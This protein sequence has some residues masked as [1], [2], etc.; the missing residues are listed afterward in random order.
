M[1]NQKGALPFIIIIAG[2]IIVLAFLVTIFK[3]KLFG[4]SKP[5]PTPSSNQVSLTPNP[6]SLAH[7]ASP[8]LNPT[9]AISVTDESDPDV[10]SNGFNEE[11]D[12]IK[13]EDLDGD[14]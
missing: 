13:P 12:N 5:A 6:T 7:L 10:N 11:G 3:L 4:G 9:P 14:S 1:L 8:S 2:V